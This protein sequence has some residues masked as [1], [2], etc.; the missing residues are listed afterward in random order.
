MRSFIG[1]IVATVAAQAVAA[2]IVW[3]LLVP[4]L[5]WAA[6][7]KPGP[8]EQ[9]LASNVLRRWVI[10]SADSRTNPLF[11]TPDNLRASRT[12][13]VEHCA[14]CHGLDGSG[15]NRFEAAFYPPVVKLTGHV[16]KFSDSEIYFIIANGIRNTAMP[17]FADAHSPD[18]IWRTVLWIRHLANLT[19]EEKASIAGEMAAGKSHHEETMGHDAGVGGHGR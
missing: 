3:F 15:R 14:A 1:G 13:Y 8:F 9:V 7:Q 10:R 5:D 19:T 6:R 17:A 16:Q 2:M 11:A 12:V 4:R 18:D